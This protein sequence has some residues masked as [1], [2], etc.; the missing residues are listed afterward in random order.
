MKHNRQ[1]PERADL[2]GQLLPDVTPLPRL[3]RARIAKAQ[4][5]PAPTQRLR[6]ERAVLG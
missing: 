3:N 4:P 2:L 1:Q 6:N 5:A